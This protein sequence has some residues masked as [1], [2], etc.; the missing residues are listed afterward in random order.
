[1]AA[2]F[3]FCWMQVDVTAQ[4]KIPYELK[5]DEAVVVTKTDD[6][7]WPAKFNFDRRFLVSINRAIPNATAIKDELVN[8]LANNGT[9]DDILF[10]W[11]GSEQPESVELRIG[12]R[13]P[14]ETAQA[15]IKVLSRQEKLPVRVLVSEDDT[16]VEENHRYFF[17]YTQRITIGSL[18][19][20]KKKP[21]SRE[22]MDAL[23]REG[24]TQKEFLKIL[25]DAK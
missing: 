15:V 9:L 20:S 18:I 1:M 19:K 5:A 21:L 14:V 10:D 24:I 12:S 13:V 4:I 11:F 6:K 17:G 16:L 22:M 7:R 3:V 25:S 8:L 2:L 23:L